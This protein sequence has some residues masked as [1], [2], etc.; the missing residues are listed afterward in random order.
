MD[1]SINKNSEFEPIYVMQIIDLLKEDQ[2]S[3][4]QTAVNA[5]KN[6]ELVIYPTETCYGVGVDA[7]NE[8]AVANLLQYKTKRADKPLSIAVSGQDMAEQYAIL[9]KTAQHIFANFLPGPIT[10]VCKGQHKVAMGV[11][12]PIG[13]IGI[14]IPDYP[15]ILE[16]IAKFGKP[17]T[18][19]SANA[20]YKKTPYCIQDILDNLSEKQKAKIGLILDAGT[21]PK[22]KTSTVMDTTLEGIHILREGKITG[23]TFESH[24]EEETGIFAKQIIEHLKGALTKQLIVIQ[25]QGDL[26]AGKTYFSKFFC[27]HLKVKELV[28]SPTFTICN[29]YHGKYNRKD[30]DIYHIDAYRL[31]DASELE[32]L[33][34][35]RIFQSPNIVLIEWAGK[36]SET[37]EPYLQDAFKIQIYIEH[38]TPT[39]RKFTYL[40][41]KEN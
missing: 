33:G 10:V 5:L 11:E 12:S 34:A 3:V 9:N 19:T 18:A 21:L 13:T 22:K 29:E 36:V 30:I 41:P 20:S 7:T 31:Y 8:K 32:D 15:F 40:L 17:I 2:E 24:S 26:G 4:L 37:I 16:L 27:K 6:G 1:S 39:E 28:N 25:M 38:I 35:K 14:R 23:S